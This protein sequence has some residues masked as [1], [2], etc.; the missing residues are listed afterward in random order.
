[1]GFACLIKLQ[2]FNFILFFS[3]LHT[4]VLFIIQ[5]FNIMDLTE[6]WREYRIFR[7]F[8][9]CDWIS[10]V[11]LK[12]FG[13]Y[14]RRYYVCSKSPSFKHGWCSM[15]FHHNVANPHYFV[16][17]IP[18]AHA[19]AYTGY[20]TVGSLLKLPSSISSKIIRSISFSLSFKF[21]FEF[22][23]DQSLFTRPYSLS[24]LSGLIKFRFTMDL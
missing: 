17:R 24:L 6:R 3:L 2:F 14:S 7:S 22:Q 5:Y 15:D 20:W 13:F 16:M 11:D 23:R 18:F 19:V 1:M 9:L 21:C 4:C 12:E 8:I 10:R